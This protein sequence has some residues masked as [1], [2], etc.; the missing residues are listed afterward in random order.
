MTSLQIEAIQAK[1]FDADKKTAFNS[2]MSVLQ[3]LGYIISSANFDTGFITGESP[4][5]HRSGGDIV[6]SIL[7]GVSTEAKTAVTV[8]IEEIQP[9]KTR[10]RLNFVERSRMYQQD[11]PQQSQDTVIM[12]PTIYNNAFNK[13]GDAIFIRQQNAPSPPT[14]SPQKAPKAK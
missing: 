10:V 13:I 8:S 2:V 12:N 7:V 11:G 5:R 1:T 6:A 4:N 3:D 14:T 9:N